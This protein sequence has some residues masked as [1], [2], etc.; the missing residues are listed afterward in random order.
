MLN[1]GWG[2]DLCKFFSLFLRLLA[3]GH[4]VFLLTKKI[5]MVNSGC[6]NIIIKSIK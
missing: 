3:L 1:Y 2:K 6:L 4:G 5:K